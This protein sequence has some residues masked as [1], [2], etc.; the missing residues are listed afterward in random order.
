MNSEF[1][2]NEQIVRAA[3]RNLA[4]GTWDSLV[5]GT[6]SETTMRRNRA[7]FDRTDIFTGQQQSACCSFGLTPIANSRQID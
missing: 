3:R 7:A 4:Q 5:G 2:S 1:V 6:E